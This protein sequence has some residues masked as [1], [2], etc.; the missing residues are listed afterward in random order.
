MTVEC[1]A[2]TARRRRRF[3]LTNRFA[4]TELAESSPSPLLEERIGK[5]T[6]LALHRAASKP[7]KLGHE[8]SQPNF[9]L[10]RA[11][12]RQIRFYP[13]QSDSTTPEKSAFSCFRRRTRA[14]AYG[15]EKSPNH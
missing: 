2:R 7:I 1:H 8:E 12:T 15:R 6:L 5:K 10:S 11:S 14:D 9:C 13:T 4:A 3:R